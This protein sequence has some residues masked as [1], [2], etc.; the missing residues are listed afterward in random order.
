MGFY[1][2][3]HEVLCHLL[4]AAERLFAGLTKVG[5]VYFREELQGIAAA[6]GLPL[7]KV[8]MMQIAYEVRHSRFCNLSQH[9]WLHGT[10]VPV[11][12]SLA[13][14]GKPCRIRGGNKKLC[15]YPRLRLR[16]TLK[17]GAVKA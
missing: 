17:V 3:W 9:H 14:C 15:V 4:Q 10:V 7:G 13:P 11:V 5:L 1:A 8:A 12:P 16:F 6:S 2:K